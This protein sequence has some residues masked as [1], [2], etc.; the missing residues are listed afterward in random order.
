ML[1]STN[2]YGWKLLHLRINIF[3]VHG[4]LQCCALLG[5]ALAPLAFCSAWTMTRRLPVAVLAGALVVTGYTH[6]FIFNDI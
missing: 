3:F 2:F 1:D 4:A 6:K 5:A